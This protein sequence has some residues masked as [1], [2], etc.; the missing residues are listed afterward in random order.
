[1][2][3][4]SHLEKAEEIRKSID[5]LKPR[6]EHVSSIVELVYGC[7]MHYLSYGCQVRFGTHKDTHVGL[8]KFL[9]KMNEEEIAIAFGKLDTIRHGRWYGG[10]DNGKTVSEAL[11]ILKQI[12]R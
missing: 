9:R 1:M 2:N 8:Q 3:E 11:K 6:E 10:K 12:E 7:S 4:E 5:K